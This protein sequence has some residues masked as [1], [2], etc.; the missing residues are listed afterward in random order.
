MAMLMI[1]KNM[2]NNKIYPYKTILKQKQIQNMLKN[3]FLNKGKLQHITNSFVA[4][5]AV[6]TASAKL[7][8]ITNSFATSNTVV[9]RANTV[10]ALIANATT[11]IKVPALTCAP[12]SWH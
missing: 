8:D 12:M 7:T 11:S 3:Y 1:T 5:D 9:G 2:N 10:S 4:S 6:S